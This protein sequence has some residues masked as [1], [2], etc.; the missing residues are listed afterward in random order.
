MIKSAVMAF[1][2]D[3]VNGC[4]MWGKHSFPKVSSYSNLFR[5]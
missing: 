2:K 4:W 5:H 1:S 3:V